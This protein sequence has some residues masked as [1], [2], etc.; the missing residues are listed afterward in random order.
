LKDALAD[1]DVDHGHGFGKEALHGV[2]VAGLDRIPE[3]ADRVT[4]PCP[5]R[6]VADSPHFVLTPTLQT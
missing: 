4:D 2:L 3:F 6:A 1:A 5:H